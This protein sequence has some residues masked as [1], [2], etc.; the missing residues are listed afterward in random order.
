VVNFS[1]GAVLRLFGIAALHWHAIDGACAGNGVD[2]LDLS[3]SR[4]LNLILNWTQEHTSPDDWETVREEIFA[5]LVVGLRDPD[6]VSQSV[7]ESEMELFA[8]FTRQS[9]E[10]ERGV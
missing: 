5:P 2:P 3:L 1:Y 6:N 4:F 8:S 9:K 10:L 7:V